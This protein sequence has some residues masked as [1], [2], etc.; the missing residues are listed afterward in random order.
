MKIAYIEAAYTDTE[1]GEDITVKINAGAQPK[2]V[3]FFESV[4][5][6]YAEAKELVTKGDTKHTILTKSL[7]DIFSSYVIPIAKTRIKEAAIE[8]A[9]ATLP[10]LDSGLRLSDLIS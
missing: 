2:G 6:N 8:E 4:L 9:I 10:N 5:E 1:T 3:K 7:W